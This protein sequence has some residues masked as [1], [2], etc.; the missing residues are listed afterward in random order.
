MRK[1]GLLRSKMFI[2]SK[3][4]TRPSALICKD[5][6]MCESLY[7]AGCC[8]LQLECT[9]SEAVHDGIVRW[10]DAKLLQQPVAQTSCLSVFLE[11][12]LAL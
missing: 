6:A 10:A 1:S 9:T 7:V 12:H 11:D 3:P 8:L 2:G 5:L 4:R